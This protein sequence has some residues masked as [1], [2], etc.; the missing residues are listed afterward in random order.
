MVEHKLPPLTPER[1]EFL[2]QEILRVYDHADSVMEALTVDGL[3]NRGFLLSLTKPFIT[4]TTNA[5]N[6]ISA[7][8]TQVVRNGQPIT[9]DLQDTM[10]GA[11][12]IF[13]ESLEELICGLE[14]KF[15]AQEG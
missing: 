7:L 9:P 13:Y 5:V 11:F 1:Q 4:Q 10:E 6:I 3:P 2:F 15:L 12:R 8:Y 14:D